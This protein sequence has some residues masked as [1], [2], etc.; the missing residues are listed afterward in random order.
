MSDPWVAPP[1]PGGPALVQRPKTYRTAV[2]IVLSVLAAACFWL[3]ADWLARNW[4]M[5]NLLNAVAK[6]EYNLKGFNNATSRLI[7]DFNEAHTNAPASQADYQDLLASVQQEATSDA[8]Q[9]LDLRDQVRAVFVLP[10]HRSVARAKQ[11]YLNHSGAWLKYLNAASK[12]GSARFGPEISG[13]WLIAIRDFHDAVP[14]APILSNGKRVDS[15][16]AP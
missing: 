9:E 14:V 8:A 11:S 6:S 4:E 12:D 16:F 2:L 10:W 15:I 7:T 1:A 3:T 13:T 5:D